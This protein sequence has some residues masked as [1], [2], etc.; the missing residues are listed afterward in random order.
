[1]PLTFRRRR[2]ID[3]RVGP[4]AAFSSP[5]RPDEFEARELS[6]R[7]AKGNDRR[8]GIAHFSRNAIIGLLP[9]PGRGPVNRSSDLGVAKNRGTT[10]VIGPI[11]GKTLDEFGGL[12]SLASRQPERPL[13]VGRLFPR[14]RRRWGRGG[15]KLR[16]AT[17]WPSASRQQGRSDPYG[18]SGRTSGHNS[19]NARRD[20]FHAKIPLE[21][22]ARPFS[23]VTLAIYGSNR[24]TTM[25]PLP[26]MK[27]LRSGS[28]HLRIYDLTP[29]NCSA[30]LTWNFCA[31]TSV[32]PLS[33]APSA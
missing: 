16:H 8:T 30:S 23:P 21:Q 15:K 27:P 9:L 17:G 1:M 22:T 13:F 7:S 24:G 12:Q 2:L 32:R 14:R 6:G 28:H 29:L 4:E 10:V 18:A 5:A 19:R 26:A 11:R 25:A 3:D 20:T 33:R 31:S